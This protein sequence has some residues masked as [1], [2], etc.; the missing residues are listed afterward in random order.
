MKKPRHRAGLSDG[1]GKPMLPLPTRVCF[2][3][4]SVRIETAMRRDREISRN[5]GPPVALRRWPLC[6][7]FRTKGPEPVDTR[8]AAGFSFAR[9]RLYRHG[10]RR[11]ILLCRE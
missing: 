1:S 8:G 2:A 3:A 10:L 7:P 5:T 4:F 6:V 9:V 11:F